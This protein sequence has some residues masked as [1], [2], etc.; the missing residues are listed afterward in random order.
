MKRA[1]TTVR[2]FFPYH[3]FEKEELE[4]LGYLLIRVSVF[5]HYLTEEEDRK[6]KI[7]FYDQ[8]I[9]EGALD[10]YMIGEKR[11]L[12]LYNDLAKDGAYVEWKGGYWSANAGDVAFTRILTESLREMIHMEIYFIGPQIR[13]FGGHDRTELFFLKNK[14]YLPELEK[15]VRGFGLHILPEKDD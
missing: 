9:E 3:E 14:D 8:A 7:M 6:C 1:P 15:K 12:A 10:E 4:E 11:F 2:H 13:V 5:D